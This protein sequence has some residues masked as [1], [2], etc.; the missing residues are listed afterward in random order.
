MGE[1]LAS[2][3]LSEATH[4][5]PNFHALLVQFRQPESAAIDESVLGMRSALSTT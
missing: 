3:A 4:T 2:E 1:K 5:G